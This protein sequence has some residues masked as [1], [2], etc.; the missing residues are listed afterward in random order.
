MKVSIY[1]AFQLLNP[2]SFEQT[3]TYTCLRVL[4]NVTGNSVECGAVWMGAERKK[5]DG[6][7]EDVCLGGEVNK[8]EAVL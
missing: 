3:T 4:M 1:A 2:Y 6:T 8:I 5:T 7:G